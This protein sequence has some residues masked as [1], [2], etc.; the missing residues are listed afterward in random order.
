MKH[1]IAFKRYR[2]PF[3]KP[4]RTAHGEWSV[5]EGFIVQVECNG[6]VGYGEI[7]PIPEFGTET[8]EAAGSFLKGL[9]A[10]GRTL[11]NLAELD[12]LPCCAF[13]LSSACSDVDSPPRRDYIIATLLPAGKSAL[14]AAKIKMGAGY[15]TFK[16]KIGVETLEDEHILFR[17]LLDILPV[18]ARLRLDANCGLSVEAME[19]WLTLLRQNIEQIDY[20]EQPLPVGQ[21]NLMSECS[22]SSQVPIALDESL[23]GPQGARWLEKGAWQGPLVV[24]PALMGERENLIMRLQPIAEQVVLS[25]VFETT[26]GLENALSLADQL[27][28]LKLAIGFDTLDVF[29]DG[30]TTFW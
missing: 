18:T 20:L 17:E 11:S 3:K 14:K 5:R 9:I 13:G 27:T 8:M 22:Q 19:S 7:A 2:R 10:G 23:N 28:G 12:H 21:E 4:L 30:L 26:V 16:W 29:A 1:L 15:S 24:K 25:S 6:R